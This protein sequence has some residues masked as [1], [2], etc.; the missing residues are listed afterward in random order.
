[1][2]ENY[3]DEQKA[4]YFLLR[5]I[6]IGQLGQYLFLQLGCI[7]LLFVSK[8]PIYLIFVIFVLMKFLWYP[9]AYKFTNYKF[10]SVLPYLG[11]LGNIICIL[12]AIYMLFFTNNFILSAC[13]LL[14]KPIF[15]FLGIFL[16]VI[17]RI[18]TPQ[19]GIIQ[20]NLISNF[21]NQIY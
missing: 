8:I 7:L 15:S 1:M 6:E 13:A 3:T 19:Y 2:L 9:F 12:I 11:I 4:Q 20:K 21:E 17:T 14:W 10:A 16:T 18:K 5:A